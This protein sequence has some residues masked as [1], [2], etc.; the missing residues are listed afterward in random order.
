MS[1]SLLRQDDGDGTASGNDSATAGVGGRASEIWGAL[2]SAVATQATQIKRGIHDMRHSEER[3]VWLKPL[4]LAGS[5][6]TQSADRVHMQTFRHLCP[7][8]YACNSRYD[9]QHCFD[10]VHES[11]LCGASYT[12]VPDD[13][14]KREAQKQKQ[15]AASSGLDFLDNL[16]TATTTTAATA[17]SSSSN[18]AAASSD[19][20]VPM[21]ASYGMNEYHMLH[22][23]Q[24]RT[25]W[26]NTT[27][28]SLHGDE[29][30][31]AI[32]EWRMRADSEQQ[33][34]SEPTPQEKKSEQNRVAAFFSDLF[35]SK[36]AVAAAASSVPAG[37]QALGSSD[38]DSPR[39][40]TGITEA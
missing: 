4:C 35:S 28:R 5:R 3:I 34:Q 11:L 33:R 12:P 26:P 24:L 32:A 22:Y 38:Q 25:Q 29:A 37:A 16:T 30:A 6:C 17:S 1:H 36:P 21:R 19:G 15:Q 7:Y 2:R 13:M 8:G 14:N 18:A 40:D 31:A 20:L 23:P 10:F 39:R 27:N 9:M